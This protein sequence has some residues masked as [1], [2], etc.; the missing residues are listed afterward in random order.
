MGICQLFLE[1]S[2]KSDL[3][4]RTSHASPQ[5]EWTQVAHWGKN[6]EIVWR[7]QFCPII[8]F[9]SFVPLLP[10]S[11][12][13]IVTSTWAVLLSSAHSWMGNVSDGWTMLQCNLHIW[14]LYYGWMYNVAYMEQHHMN[15]KK[16]HSRCSAL[17]FYHG[18][19]A[20]KITF[21]GLC[22]FGQEKL[23]QGF[24]SCFV[25]LPC[26]VEYLIEECSVGAKTILKC[27]PLS[28]PTDSTTIKYKPPFG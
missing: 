7:L 20:N 17:I 9:L 28:E 8:R 14:N 10:G 23:Y 26:S 27:P 6:Q 18:T 21:G 4:L 13:N 15:G 16:R 3:S 11:K 1:G 5:F 24:L 12:E 22:Q 25:F 19:T 2:Q